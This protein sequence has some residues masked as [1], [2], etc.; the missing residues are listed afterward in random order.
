M[1]SFTQNG[2]VVPNGRV[3]T[4]TVLRSCV[5]CGRLSR[6]SYCAKHKPKP[7][8]ASKRR[9]RMGL[10][11][12]NWETLRRKVLARDRT[13][14]YLGASSVPVASIIWWK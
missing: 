5:R 10:S 14:C 12:G 4:V 13:C 9:E 11:G 7:W 2:G 1:K 6:E 8:A 3:R